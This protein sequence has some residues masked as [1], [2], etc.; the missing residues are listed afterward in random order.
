MTPDKAAKG[1]SAEPFRRREGGCEL[2]DSPHHRSAMQALH[3][4]QLD[5]AM[6]VFTVREVGPM[7]VQGLWAAY[8]AFYAVALV[9]WQFVP[10]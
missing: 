5:R 7:V 9:V 4:D 8:A 10:R 3:G 6:A 2:R 1:E